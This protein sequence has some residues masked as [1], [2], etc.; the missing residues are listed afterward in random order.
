MERQKAVE[1]VKTAWVFLKIDIQ[2]KTTWFPC[3]NL[4]RILLILFTKSLPS[5]EPLGQ[6]CYWDNWLP[7]RSRTKEQKLLRR[8]TLKS[9]SN[10]GPP[11][12][13]NNPEFC[14]NLGLLASCFCSFP[15]VTNRSN[16][17]L[18]LKQPH[19][20]T[21]TPLGSHFFLGLMDTYQADLFERGSVRFF[22]L[23]LRKRRW[24]N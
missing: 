23:I 11:F 2:E 10:M 18:P 7:Q 22:S 15:L 14:R 5:I 21:Q 6:C 12:L 8:Q 13:R 16:I 3:L 9:S 4:R 24:L 1:I 20:A 19:T 17:V